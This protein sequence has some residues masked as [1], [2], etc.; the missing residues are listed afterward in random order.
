MLA[1]HPLRGRALPV[2]DVVQ[3]VPGATVCA[4]TVGTIGPATMPTTKAAKAAIEIISA[5]TAVSDRRRSDLSC[6]T[7]YFILQLPKTRLTHTF[8]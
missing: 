5:T 3:L 2:G 6:P 8:P 1:V 4:L 7:M